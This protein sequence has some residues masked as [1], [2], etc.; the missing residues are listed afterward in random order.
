M[1]SVSYTGLNL[2]TV[3]DR[4]GREAQASDGEISSALG[5]ADAA[6]GRWIAVLDWEVR[7]DAANGKMKGGIRLKI[8]IYSLR[9]P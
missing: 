7:K 5:K 4:L 8:D 9:K 3:I 2:K 1:S 6:P